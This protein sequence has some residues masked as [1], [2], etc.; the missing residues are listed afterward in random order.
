[1]AV[2][3]L[4]V[5]SAFFFGAVWLILRVTRKAAPEAETPNNGLHWTRR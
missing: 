1:M 4:T 5:P 2:F 3:I